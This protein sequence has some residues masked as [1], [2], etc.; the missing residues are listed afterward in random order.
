MNFLYKMTNKLSLWGAYLSGVFL[1]SLVILVMTEIIGRHF[2]DTSTMIADEYSG[3]IYLSAIFLGLAYTFEQNAHIR[4]NILSEKISKK[5]N[6]KIDIIAGI[7]SILVLAFI[8]YR[9]LLFTYDSYDMDML[10]EAVSETP[11]YLTQIVMPVGI[12]LFIL[13]VLSFVIKKVK[14]DI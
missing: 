11:L 9:V 13:S 6:R 12:L 14:N 2:F 7:I 1:I 8:F 3:Y 10:S 5:A 4:I